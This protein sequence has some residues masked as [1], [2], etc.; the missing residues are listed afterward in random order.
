MS[1]G[2][3]LRNHACMAVS[4]ESGRKMLAVTPLPASSAA[5]LRVWASRAAL[6]AA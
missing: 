4:T 6:V 1:S 3:W 2:G 5:G